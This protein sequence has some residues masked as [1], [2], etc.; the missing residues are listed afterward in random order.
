MQRLDVIVERHHAVLPRHSLACAEVIEDVLQ[1]DVRLVVLHQTELRGKR[2]GRRQVE[3]QV[4]SS[5]LFALLQHAV[6]QFRALPTQAA[7][8]HLFMILNNCVRRSSRRQCLA[9]GIW[10]L[11]VYGEPLEPIIVILRK[12]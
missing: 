5:R 9:A 7:A 12:Q 4:S 3:L 2:N 11:N 10:T 1:T 6:C 8:T